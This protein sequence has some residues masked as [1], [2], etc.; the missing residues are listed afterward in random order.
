MTASVRT[1]TPASSARSSPSRPAPARAAPS[2][3]AAPWPW[4]AAAARR[5]RSR[6][7]AGY[8]ISQV[9]V[10]GTPNAAAASAGTYTFTNVQAN[11]TIAATF[12]QS[13]ATITSSAGAGG[14]ISPIGTQTVAIGGSQTYTITPNNGYPVAHVL[15]DRVN[16]AGG[17]DVRHVHVHQRDGEPHDSPRRSRRTCRRASPCPRLPA[18]MPQAAACRSPGQRTWR[19][20]AA[21]SPSGPTAAAAGTSARS[22]PPTARPPTRPTSPSTCR[23]APPTTDLGRL[24]ADRGQ[25]RLDGVRAEQR[26]LHGHGPWPSPCP[27][28]PAATPRT[29]ACRSPGRPASPSP[30][31]SSPSGRDSGSGWYIGKIVPTNGDH[32]Y[33]TNVTLDVPVGSGYSIWVGY[34]PTAGSGAWT[35]FGQSSGT[36]T[37]TPPL[38]ITVPS[39]T[40]TYAQ[41]SSLPVS[42]TTSAAL[43]AGGEFAV[44][45]ESAS[46][47]YIGKIVP[48]ERRPPPTR[49][50]SPSTCPRAAATRSGSATGPPWAAAP[51]RCSVK[52]AGRSR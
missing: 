28:S 47:W 12:T 23:R 33:A 30:A 3:R 39:I 5:S 14:S 29:A 31:A 18:A 41:S 49:P 1:P 45:A 21:S 24:P 37:V 32:S 46:G 25:R 52:A 11:Q 19:S 26:D 7:N 20:A 43:L 27:R 36:F 50:D 6:P 16:D 10:N 48:T 15:V 2:R 17:R 35:V 13:A 9:L 42:W 51:G 4:A 22:S 8:R 38:V 44:W 34:R 40:G